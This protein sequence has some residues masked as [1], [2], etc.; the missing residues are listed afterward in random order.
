MWPPGGRED[1]R[2]PEPTIYKLFVVVTI[3]W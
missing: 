3:R 1:D 2:T